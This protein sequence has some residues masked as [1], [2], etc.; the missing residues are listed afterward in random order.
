MNAIAQHKTHRL[1]SEIDLQLWAR[2]QRRRWFA[3]TFGASLR[4]F[5]LAFP[6]MSR[7]VART[8][9]RRLFQSAPS[10][11]DSGAPSGVAAH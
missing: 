3:R 5:A 9:V 2:E 10:S 8:C 6:M 11:G 7:L 4:N 1:V